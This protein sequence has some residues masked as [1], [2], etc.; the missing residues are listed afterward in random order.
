MKSIVYVFVFVIIIS[1]CKPKS[2]GTFVVSG[3][4]E[5]V[6]PKRILLQ[7]IPFDGSAPVV[8]DSGT[9]TADGTFEL[10]AIAQQEG[11]Y[12]VGV[13]NGPQAIFINDNDKIRIELDANNFRHPVIEGSEASKSLYT[14]IENYIQKDSI[15]ST[16][17]YK[18][19]SLRKQPRNDS[20]IQALQLQGM[21]GVTALKDYVS[22]FVKESKSPAAAHFAIMQAGRTQIMQDKEIL[23]LATSASDKF[24]EH[25]GLALLKSKII[26]S[27]EGS[28]SSSSLV[29]QPA[30]ELTMP[31]VSGK[32][33]SISSFKGKYLLVDFWASW[34]GPCRQENPVV[35]AAY[36]RY[37]N[38]NFTILGVSLDKDKGAWLQAI[39][40]DGLAWNHMSDLKYWESAAVNAY[41]FEGIPF[42]VLIDPQGKI[43]AS[44][45]R[46]PDLESKLAEVLK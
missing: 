46:G 5:N 34:C 6:Q 33:L 30:P 24:K 2:K 14:F 29:N 35:V 38:K 11:L 45:L 21:Q 23:A 13:Q 10:K 42:N 40:K 22:K 41:K 32:P 26:V 43:I 27:S 28:S 44:N 19:D 9:L 36:N 12:F 3:K 25:Q 37:K 39:Q 4:I 1:S 16:T 20:A 15:L 17:F 31:D 8:I 18:V 7:E